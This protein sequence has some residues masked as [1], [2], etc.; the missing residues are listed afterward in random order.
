MTVDRIAVTLAGLAL[1]AW[2]VWYFFL[3]EAPA[4]AATGETVQRLRID[5]EGG[6]T[7]AVVRVR[8]GRPVR[9]EFL[10]KDAN[11]CTEEV[12]FPSFGLRTYLPVN[13]LTPVEFTPTESGTFEF[14]C[15]MGMVRGELIVEDA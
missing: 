4:A 9:L 8:R 11:S 5:V 13:Q 6:Y 7:P 14:T 3:A 12:L 15:G 10:R 1:V 2:V